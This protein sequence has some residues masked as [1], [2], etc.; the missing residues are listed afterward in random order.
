[1]SVSV[2]KLHVLVGY[3]MLS[4]CD[5]HS[6]V[7]HYE[8]LRQMNEI[9]II[10][11]HRPNTP[12]S[13]A[14]LW[15]GPCPTL[16]PASD[17]WCRHMFWCIWRHLSDLV[18]WSYLD[19]VWAIVEQSTP[20]DCAEDRISSVFNHVVSADGRQGLP[21]FS[22]HRTHLIKRYTSCYVRRTCPS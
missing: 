10:L 3:T 19:S 14:P 21:L 18:S 12:I 6:L 4:V 2:P 9:D 1:M 13:I 5:A 22:V 16:H 20:T 15:S 17:F 8:W 11:A 7:W